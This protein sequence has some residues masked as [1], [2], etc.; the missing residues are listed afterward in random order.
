MDALDSGHI[1][2]SAHLLQLVQ[3]TYSDGEN[4]TIHLADYLTQLDHADAH[5]FDW[6]LCAFGQNET[7]SLAEAARWGGKARAGFENSLW[8]ANGSLATDN[9]A[10]IREVDAALRDVTGSLLDVH[11]RHLLDRVSRGPIWPISCRG[12]AQL[13][14]TSCANAFAAGSEFH[15][16]A[17]IRPYAERI[18]SR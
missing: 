5:T 2:G 11:S 15:F 13:I 14:G 12:I 1:P 10:R 17:E 8:N 4:G 6:M 18:G 9:A 3:G 16:G 7:A